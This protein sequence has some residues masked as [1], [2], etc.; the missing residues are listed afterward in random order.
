[1][2]VRVRARARTDLDTILDYSIVEHGEAAAEAYLRAIGAAFD[3][4]ADYPGIGAARRD[5]SPDVRSFPVGEHRIY[6]VMTTT[7]VSIVRVLHKAMDPA[8]HV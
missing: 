6:Y 7:H 2:T 4:L 5:L 3:R 1:M 8:R